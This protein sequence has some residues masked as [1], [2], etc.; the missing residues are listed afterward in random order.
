MGVKVKQWKGAWWVFV[1]H[2]GKRK[3]KRIG[4]KK[5]A[6]GV[7]AEITT[8]L[9][10]GATL[11]SA[12]PSTYTVS[13][14]KEAAER[15]IEEQF[16]LG[17][18]REHT[19]EQYLDRLRL[20]AYDRI[21]SKPVTEVARDDVKSI[22]SACRAGGKSVSL[23]RGVLAPIRGLFNHLIDEG[24]LKGSDAKDLPNPAE[25]MARYVG[26]R[27][28][29]RQHVDFLLPEEEPK[30]LQTAG[31]FCPREFPFVLTALRA[32]LR[33]GEVAGLQ[34]ADVDFKRRVI[35][36]RRSCGWKRRVELPKNGRIRRVDM[37]P[38]LVEELAR[39]LESV[40]LEAAV[41]GW[42]DEER[43]WLFPNR[44]G[45]PYDRRNFD[46]KVWRPLLKQAG[47]RPRRFHDLRHTF[48][49]RLIQQGTNLL[50]IRDQLGHA[51]VQITLDHYGHLVPD[52]NKGEVA[53][54][55]RYADL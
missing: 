23:A 1:N 29:P 54:L 27:G 22:L 20:Y 5:T 17:H 19:K 42:G 41:K 7:A 36:V 35:E 44:N 39:H 21:G 4:D 48:A 25:R 12:T 9:A 24:R 47:L 45:K 18:I 26:R 2:Q 13:T 16:T 32:G 53:K 8:R 34:N 52:A 37:S 11:A 51:S 28:D 33:Y 31:A 38:Q 50:Y 46:R 40:G 55:D 43:A 3:A 30:L 14:F 49:S 10:L 6:K 15:W